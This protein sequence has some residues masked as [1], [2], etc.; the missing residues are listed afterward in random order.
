L[1]NLGQNRFV[2][3]PQVGIS[4]LSGKWTTEVTADLAFYTDN[5]EFWAGNKLEQD[6]LFLMHGHLIYNF[7]PGLWLGAS[8]GFDYGGESRVNGIDKKDEKQ[9]FGWGVSGAYPINRY[10]GVKLAYLNIR[11]QE[12]TGSDSDSVVLSLSYAW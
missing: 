7:R 4:H 5:D 9:N 8:M 6:P 3:R 10:M 1:L 12:P 2:F 11:T